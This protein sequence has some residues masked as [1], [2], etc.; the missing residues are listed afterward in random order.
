M[1]ERLR[2]ANKKVEEHEAR[3]RAEAEEKE[4]LLEE[5]FRDWTKRDF[6]AFVRACEKYGRP[7]TPSD[8][9]YAH[10]VADW[11]LRPAR[12][13]LPRRAPA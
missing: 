12:I 1:H 7:P 10:S 13:A 4:R 8:T 5:G 2:I 11:P 6:M 9:T 3:A